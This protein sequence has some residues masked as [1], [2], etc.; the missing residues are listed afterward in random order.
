MTDRVFYACCW[1]ANMMLHESP[2]ASYL[3]G[4][5]VAAIISKL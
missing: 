2:K 4:L 3:E 5:N 1:F